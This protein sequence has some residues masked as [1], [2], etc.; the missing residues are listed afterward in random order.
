[1]LKEFG[2]TVTEEK[3]YLSLIK[4]GNSPASRI[5]KDTQ[6]HRTTVYD[7][8]DRLT[9]KGFVSYIIKNKIKHYSPSSP[10]KLLDI[11]LEE[12]KNA[13]KR[14]DLAKILI[15][16]IG[17]VKSDSEYLDI[18]EIFI[19]QKGQRTIMDDIIEEG[20]SFLILGSGG[21]FQDDL[22]VYTEN[23]AEK[24]TKKKIYAKIIATEG[25]NAPIWKMNTIK[26]IKK[27]YQS[28]VTTFIYG[29]KVAIFI[30]EEPMTIILIK[31]KN[32]SNSY[33]NYFNLIWEIA[34]K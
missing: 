5:I 19:G 4:L 12:R 3:V 32:V 13:E 6:L 31:N 15:K 25:T 33:K 10:S 18:A 29:E 11:A 9:E 8:L 21:R 14:Q 22:D 34:H 23:W 17:S 28:P 26:F 30:N 27:E 1:M 16:K 7:V 24:R 20:K 2:L